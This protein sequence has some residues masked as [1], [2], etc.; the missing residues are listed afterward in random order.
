MWNLAVGLAVTA[1]PQ[2]NLALA[3]AALGVHAV[4]RLRRAVARRNERHGQAEV[5]RGGFGEKVR[6]LLV[7]GWYRY[8]RPTLNSR[9]GS[10]Q[11]EPTMMGLV[12]TYG[13]VCS[14]CLPTEL[15]GRRGDAML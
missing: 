10:R 1:L 9:H 4:K 2:G 13:A 5:S 15:A 12:A 3:G 11:S 6:M 8:D 7:S 14:P